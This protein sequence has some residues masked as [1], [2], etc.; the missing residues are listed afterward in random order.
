M[1]TTG[2][3]ER[4]DESVRLQELEA[5][6]ETLR[7]EN[8]ELRKQIPQPK[9][10]SGQEEGKQLPQQDQPPSAKTK[11]Q[12]RR[13]M[14]IALG[15]DFG[16]TSLLD[17]SLALV[18]ITTPLSKASV[19][20]LVQSFIDA[21]KL[22]HGNIKAD[23]SDWFKREF[24][25]FDGNP[26]LKAALDNF[27]SILIDVAKKLRPLI[28]MSRI[29]LGVRL[30]VIAI[31]SYVDMATDL[32]VSF[33]FFEKGE[34]GWGT[35]TGLILTDVNL[36][37]SRSQMLDSCPQHPVYY[38][39]PLTTKKL[40]KF[41][42]GFALLSVSH[43]FLTAFTMAVVFIQF[44]GVR[45]F[46]VMAIE[47]FLMALYKHF[48]DRELFAL[49]IMPKPSKG[50]STKVIGIVICLIYTLTASIT[51]V[52]HSKNPCELGPHATAF[53][54]IWRIVTNT[55]TLVYTLPLL[56]NDEKLPW[57][58]VEAGYG[59]IAAAVALFFIGSSMYWGNMHSE[60]N[61]SRWW[62]RQTGKDHNAE[63]W[64][65]E[66]ILNGNATKDEDRARSVTVLHPLY[67]HKN[68]VQDWILNLPSNYDTS[69]PPPKFMTQKFKSHIIDIFKWWGGGEDL[70]AVE[71][72]LDKFE[73]FVPPKVETQKSGKTTKRFKSNNKIAPAK[74][75]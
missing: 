24:P 32:L 17:S 61:P 57:M 13:R 35:A 28:K 59:T 12:E 54:V 53:M 34:T 5:E 49:S 25:S 45:I 74:E 67:W 2:Q 46:F 15:E 60:H 39:V 52:P 64:V 69:S 50:L 68:L 4:V 30:F 65:R 10:P 42:L 31:C 20:E 40:A 11:D 38:F 22:S 73:T 26:Q 18:P 43:F 8:A 3:D 21:V 27:Q 66:D 14:S 75:N 56:I 6:V 36:G 44:G 62:K 1:A 9:V 71:A 23:M 19:S 41:C 63:M 51:Y 72:A 7:A 33:S 55:I 48:V 70:A 58:T 29:G 16:G 37:I 47:N